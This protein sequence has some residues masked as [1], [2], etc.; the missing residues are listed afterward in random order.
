ME[1]PP[2][3]RQRV[4]DVLDK[5][6]EWDPVVPTVG[7]E[8]GPK[9]LREVDVG[10]TEY[11]DQSFQ[12]FDCIL[13]YRYTP[14]KTVFDVRY[15][16][17]VVEEI[18]L[19]GKVITLQ[20]MKY[21]NPQATE[22]E[23]TKDDHKPDKKGAEAEE[24]LDLTPLTDFFTPSQITAL[25]TLYQT[26]SPTE[27]ET[28][29]LTKDQRTTIH[30]TLRTL[31]HGKLD[32]QATP[33]GA[34]RVT[35]AK[36]T[37]RRGERRHWPEGQYL[38]FTIKK[39]NRDTMST[40]SLLAKWLRCHHRAL[41]Y[42]GTKDRRA[43]TT[44]RMSAHKMKAER[45][46]ALN[47]LGGPM[48]VFLGDFEYSER[49]IQLGDLRGNQF[50]I[51]LREL[52]ASLTE[53]ELGVA[54]KSLRERGFINYYGMQRFG[55]SLV[56]TH[57]VGAL[58]LNGL[59]RE[60]CEM[61]LDVKAGGMNDSLEAREAYVRGDVEEAFELMPRNCIA[62]RAILGVLKINPKHFSGAFQAVFPTIRLS[63]W[64]AN[65]RFLGI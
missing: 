35:Y 45:M 14:L 41:G 34:I 9:Y 46:A 50:I 23:K 42:A 30:H 49:G 13:K 31:F 1:E 56:S 59:W 61:I 54:M 64:E 19:D 62:E 52:P 5:K 43:V 40:A 32:S 53:E 16:D 36:G 60:A 15:S 22:N 6:D 26:K 20:N 48:G 51:T 2:T 65:W 4:D 28:A 11:V 3:K 44:Q 47:A 63:F 24:P 12:G 21:Q 18:G 33:S 29:P 10:I 58:L 38:H 37:A 57:S 55:T 17:F 39:N 27:V 8:M 25:Q 7:D